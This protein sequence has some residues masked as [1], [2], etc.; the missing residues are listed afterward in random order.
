V[1]DSTYRWFTVHSPPELA[2][3][4]T[5]VGQTRDWGG[6]PPDE[7]L[8]ARL[9]LARD[10]TGN[11]R[12]CHPLT[13]AAEIA[14]RI[15]FIQRGQCEFG[16]KALHAQEAGAI[17][18]IVFNSNPIIKYCGGFP[19]QAGAYGSLV[20]IP[21]AMYHYEDGWGQC[22]GYPLTSALLA[23]AE[24]TV[25]LAPFF[26]GVAAEPPVEGI[27]GE[28]SAVQPNPFT[29]RASFTVTVSRSQTVRLSVVDALGRQVAAVFD[30]PLAAGAARRFTLSGTGL[31]PG[32]YLLR[33]TGDSYVQ[34]R[35]VVRIR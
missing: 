35:R 20:T 7:G 6:Q 15:A 12:A 10:S 3:S 17:A 9:V 8:T 34:T 11:Y 29:D 24:I 22:D 14:G 18:F 32:V 2:R 28:L 30:G 1:R 27:L 19:M 31:S 25:T 5:L 4:D 21:G 26:V 13:N 16:L 33:A 23:G